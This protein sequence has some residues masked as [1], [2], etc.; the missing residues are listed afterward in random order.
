[1]AELAMDDGKSAIVFDDPVTSLDHLWRDSFARRIAQEAEYRQVIVFTHDVAFLNS[2]Q[3]E[4]TEIDIP[5]HLQ[6]VKMIA[7]KAGIVS[8]DL[9]WVAQKTRHRLDDLEKRISPLRNL[10]K[11]GDEDKYAEAVGPYYSRLRATIERAIVDV[12][13]VN[14]VQRHREQ[15]V[16]NHD[17]I[18]RVSVIERDD[19]EDVSKLHKRCCGITEAHDRGELRSHQGAPDPD[20]IKTDLDSLSSLVTDIRQRQKDAVKTT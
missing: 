4:A 14:I 10:F 3:E 13:L 7:R 16:V 15:V 5:L 2:L 8:D 20:M 1:M 12:F 6:Q 9:P 17:R 11:E 19:W 18:K